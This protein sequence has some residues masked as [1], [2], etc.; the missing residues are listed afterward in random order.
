[1]DTK[2]WIEHL[3]K[4][5][6]GLWL[7]PIVAI[8]VSS[9]IIF[10]IK[11]YFYGSSI[12]PSFIDLVMVF[13]I[14]VGGYYM[15]FAALILAAIKLA[16]VMI[17]RPVTS[18]LFV[19]V[20]NDPVINVDKKITTEKEFLKMMETTRKGTKV[21][22]VSGVFF[23]L[24]AGTLNSLFGDPVIGFGAIAVYI[25]FGALYGY[26]LYKLAWIGLMPIPNWEEINI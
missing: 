15:W 11:I 5:H 8:G 22:V 23:G 20:K 13:M 12:T 16:M 10:Y 19:K 3:R 9:K 24:I 17:I 2:Q 26:A 14:I 1:M 4:Y 21:F 6:L 25:V 18:L 7:V